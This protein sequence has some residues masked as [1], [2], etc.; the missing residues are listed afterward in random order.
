MELDANVR[1]QFL[2]V[3]MVSTSL[4]IGVAIFAGVAVFLN[5]SGMITPLTG[6][7]GQTMRYGAIVFVFGGLVL[8]SVLGKRPRKVVAGGGASAA[9]K[10]YVVHAILPQAI[11]EGLGLTGIAAGILTGSE[12][13][14]L[15]FAAASVSSLFVGRPRLR[16]LESALHAAASSSRESST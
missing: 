6:P 16:D 10:G 14:I 13:W 15:I 9:V 5:R 7:T 8:A 12:S 4:M 2:V 3:M 11:R 1:R